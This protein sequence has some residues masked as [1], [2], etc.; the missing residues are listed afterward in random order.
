MN[1]TI[2]EML[3]NS[4]YYLKEN[5]FNEGNYQTKFYDRGGG[6][7]LDFYYNQYR[8]GDK[9]KEIIFTDYL[10]NNNKVK[11]KVYKDAKGFYFMS[12][13]RKTYIDETFKTREEE[14]KILY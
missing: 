7:L 9:I 13:G 4:E 11:K 3:Q 10:R 8:K 14:W 2:S 5:A 1:I 6:W 12:Y